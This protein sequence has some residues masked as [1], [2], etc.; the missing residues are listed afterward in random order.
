MTFSCL[1]GQLLY[2]SLAYRR[3][4]ETRGRDW[5]KEEPSQDSH[6]ESIA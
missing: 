4:I 3:S 5:V 2:V 1:P 6:G